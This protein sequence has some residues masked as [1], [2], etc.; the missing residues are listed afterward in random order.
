LSDDDDADD[1]DDDDDDDDAD[2][3]DDMMMLIMVMGQLRNQLINQQHPTSNHA[4]WTF[5]H[6]YYSYRRAVRTVMGMVL[7]E[8]STKISPN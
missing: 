3:A 8:V 5:R 4:I 1:D 7:C 2:D 6:W